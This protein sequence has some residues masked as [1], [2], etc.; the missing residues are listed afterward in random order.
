MNLSILKQNFTRYSPIFYFAINLLIFPI[1]IG[2]YSH[3][4]VLRKDTIPLNYSHSPSFSS[5]VGI[6]D[7]CILTENEGNIW[8]KPIPKGYCGST[9]KYYNF[10]LKDKTIHEPELTGMPK[11]IGKNY[12]PEN[13]LFLPKQNRII[14]EAPVSKYIVITDT[15]NQYISSKFYPK[16]KRH[17][18]FTSWGYRFQLE[19]S[20]YFPFISDRLPPNLDKNNKYTFGSVPFSELLVKGTKRLKYRSYVDA[21]P[22]QFPNTLI[23]WYDRQYFP[24]QKNQ[25]LWY[26]D[27]YRSQVAAYTPARNSYDCYTLPNQVLLNNPAWQYFDK[28]DS[29]YKGVK[30][31]REHDKWIVNSE[32]IKVGYTE[33]EYFRICSDNQSVLFRSTLIITTDSLLLNQLD[34]LAFS[35]GFDISRRPVVNGMPIYHLYEWIALEPEIQHLHQIIVPRGQEIQA[36]EATTLQL[37][38]FKM[39]LNDQYQYIPALLNW[40]LN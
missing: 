39:I 21:F 33:Q 20:L 6:I 32:N 7:H 24:D 4:Q 36:V 34:S 2:D 13:A 40:N 5:F 30:N 11:R 22:C 12:Y 8:I 19:N 25:K 15:L 37:T 9:I 27:N 26:M 10:N 1:L 23:F 16:N 38:G 29:L 17:T 28:I 35:K 14:W 18:F 3:A 31:Y